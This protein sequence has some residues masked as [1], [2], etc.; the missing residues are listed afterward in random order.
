[1][2]EITANAVMIGAAGYGTDKNGKRVRKG[3]G[4]RHNWHTNA[5]SGSG[6]AVQS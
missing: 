3:V 5:D 1:M 2:R 6:S 4:E